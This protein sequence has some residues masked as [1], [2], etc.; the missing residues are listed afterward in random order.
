[1]SEDSPAGSG[2]QSRALLDQLFQQVCVAEGTLA[3][4]VRL[5]PAGEAVEAVRR[6]EVRFGNPRDNLI[7]LTP[8]LF[9]ELALALTPIQRRQIVDAWDFYYLTQ[10]VTV[11]PGAGAQFG[12]LYCRLDFGPK[13]AGEPIVD[14]LVPT[15]RWEEKLSG[16]AHITLGAN[17]DVSLSAAAAVPLDAA[18][19]PV[20]A[21]GSAGA[22]ASAEAHVSAPG[23]SFSLGRT[24]IAAGGQGNSTCDW[25]IEKP[26]ILREQDVCFALVFKVPKGTAA[27]SLTGHADVEPSFHWLARALGGV[28]DALDSGMKALL[29][30]SDAQRRGAERL[31]IPVDEAWDLPLTPSRHP[32]S[33]PVV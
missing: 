31:P 30:Q 12:R 16:G 7:R 11:W 3:G 28:F 10:T 9:G 2:A 15:S 29:R 22:Q 26:E 24:S 1:M 32:S 27:T 21:Q 23:F 14:A 18:G 13:G 4:G 25:R 17:G 5:G 19:V 6:T 20:H 8:A 33:R